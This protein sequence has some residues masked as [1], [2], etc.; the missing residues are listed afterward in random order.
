MRIGDDRWQVQP[1]GGAMPSAVGVQAG[2]RPVEE[3]KRA[4]AVSASAVGQADTDLG[5]ALP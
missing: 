1:V 4:D 3:T 5:K 2:R